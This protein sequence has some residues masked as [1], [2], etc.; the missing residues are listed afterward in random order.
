MVEKA[1]VRCR[2]TKPLA[3]FYRHARMTDGHLTVCKVCVRARVL[4]HRLDHIEKIRAYDRKR[5]RLPHRRENAARVNAGWFARSPA[6][7]TAQARLWHAVA[8]GNIRKGPCEVC[9]AIR[10]HGHHDDYLK[11]LNVRWLCAAHH[12][13]WHTKNGPGK[14]AD[15]V[16]PDGRRSPNKK[17]AA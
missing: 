6:A 1:C 15:A 7:R 4:L 3:E 12:R 8:T 9:G 17:K 13:Q 14:N 5:A 16:I 10:V 2:R 11:P